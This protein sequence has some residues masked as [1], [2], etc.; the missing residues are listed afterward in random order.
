MRKKR[1][2]IFKDTHLPPPGWLQGCFICNA[3]TGQTEDFI[4]NLGAEDT[5]YVVYVCGP[6][7]QLKDRNGPL[8][9]LYESQIL[10]YILTHTG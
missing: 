9:A 5:Q 3:I 6:C 1:F 10:D 4:T 7:K 8:C 2:Y